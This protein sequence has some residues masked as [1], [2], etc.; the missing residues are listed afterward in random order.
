[1]LGNRLKQFREYNKISCEILAKLLGIT[2]TDYINF[3]NDTTSPSILQI[4]RL[5]FF[6]NVTVDE[7]YGFT[8]RLTLN[9]QP[10]RPETDNDIVDESILKLSQLSWDEIQVLLHYRNSDNKEEIIKNIIN[11]QDKK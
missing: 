3:E 5:A 2:E 8:P 1:M 4:E 11:E 6:Y 9:S 7:F 10:E